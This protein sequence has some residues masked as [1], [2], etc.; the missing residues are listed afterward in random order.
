[1]LHK[2]LRLQLVYSTLN[3]NLDVNN[4]IPVRYNY[5]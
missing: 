5:D 1:M 4:L 2:F 3:Y